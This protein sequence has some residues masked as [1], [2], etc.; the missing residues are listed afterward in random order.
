MGL[1]DTRSQMGVKLPIW[2]SGTMTAIKFASCKKRRMTMFPNKRSLIALSVL[3]LSANFSNSS[4]ALHPDSTTV[5]F[6][7]G[8]DMVYISCLDKY[9]DISWNNTLTY[10]TFLTRG[11]I[12]HYISSWSYE[13]LWTASDGSG[14]TWIGTGF[15]PETR[16]GVPGAGQV[17]GVGP[18]TVQFTSHEKVIPV[19]DNEG[20]SLLLNLRVKITINENGEVKVYSAPESTDDWNVLCVGP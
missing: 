5:N 14:D 17:P 18:G 11:G 6:P 9:V 20:P 2:L 16:N 8:H 13:S 7:S 4:L 12:G 10:R 19:G 15:S 3:G 1:A